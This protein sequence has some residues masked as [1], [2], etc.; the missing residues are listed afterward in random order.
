MYAQRYG[1]LPIARRTGGLVDTIEDG[2]NGFLFVEQTADS[3]LGAIRRAL[4]VHAH[5][6]LLAAMR[7]QAMA[8]PL[9]WS[10]SVRP[11]DQ[12]YR[13]LLTEPVEARI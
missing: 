2:V 9:F 5:P 3:Y 4:Q 7:T 6:Q 11:Y 12:L 8:A 10:E 1:T 13:S